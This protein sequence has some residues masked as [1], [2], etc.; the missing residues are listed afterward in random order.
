MSKKV[1]K[2]FRIA[3]FRPNDSDFSNVYAIRDGSFFDFGSGVRK[4]SDGFS[5]AARHGA[6]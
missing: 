6:R 5:A 4:F 2:N 1:R 3:R